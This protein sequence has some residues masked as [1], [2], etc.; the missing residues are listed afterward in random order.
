MTAGNWHFFEAMHRALRQRES[1][2][3]LNLIATAVD[4][5]D[6]AE[7]PDEVPN[8]VPS[9]VEQGDLAPQAGALALCVSMCEA[10][11]V[12]E[13]TGQSNI[14]TGTGPHLQCLE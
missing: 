14:R 3:P 6:V 2:K 9:Q 4:S 8:E 11:I 12:E 10:H 7:E 1:I 5:S 13:C